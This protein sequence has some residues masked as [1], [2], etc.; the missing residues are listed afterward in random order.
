MLENGKTVI[1]TVKACEYGLMDQ[2]ML[3]NLKITKPMVKECIYGLVD[4][5][6]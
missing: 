4:K 1:Q 2:N 3:G 5:S 6:L